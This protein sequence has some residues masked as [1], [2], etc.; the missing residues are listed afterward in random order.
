[1]PRFAA[2]PVITRPSSASSRQS[3]PASRACPKQSPC[4]TPH[5]S[6]FAKLGQGRAVVESDQAASM[7][8]V[9]RMLALAKAHIRAGR[10]RE[11]EIICRDL[12][13]DFPKCGQAWN[14][15][16]CIMAQRNN[17]LQAVACFER[18]I[19]EAPQEGS[20]HANLSEIYRRAG[21]FEQAVMH[22]HRAVDLAPRHTEARLN[23]GL[24][25]LD[26]KKPD[27][28]LKQ[29]DLAAERMPSSVKAWFGK[30][31]ALVALKRLEEAVTVFRRCAQLAPQDP[32]VWLELARAHLG[33]NDPGNALADAKRAAELRPDAIESAVVLADAHQQV[34]EFAEAERF[35]RKALTARPGLVA[36]RYRLAQ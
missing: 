3:P 5:G 22:G 15:L 13:Q 23:L 19:A 16:G 30:G 9:D 25:L 14:H 4:P 29:F 6:I 21:L 8:A 17:G 20:F 2:K 32:N 7:A 24:A 26:L 35:L 27:E 10:W 31:R 34:G 33:L 12:V 1:M 28:A 18:A 11:A 36:L